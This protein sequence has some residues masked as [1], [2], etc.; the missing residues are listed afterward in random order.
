MLDGKNGFRD[1]NEFAGEKEIVDTDDRASKRIFDGSEQSVGGAF[2]DGAEGGIKRGAGNGSDGGAEKLESG[3]FAESAGLALE[4]DAHLHFSK[5]RSA[6]NLSGLG[7][8]VILRRHGLS[9]RKVRITAGNR[10]L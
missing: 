4:G 9:T 2:L 7:E 5:F 6:H 8:S 1:D 3:F 10:A